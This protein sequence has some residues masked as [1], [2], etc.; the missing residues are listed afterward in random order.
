MTLRALLKVAR[1]GPAKAL[2]LVSAVGWIAT[3]LAKI[4]R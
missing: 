3:A 4:D 2:L 1:R